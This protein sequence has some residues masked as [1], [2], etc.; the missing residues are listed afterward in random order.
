MLIP[1]IKGD[2]ERAS[3]CVQAAT[4]VGTHSRL[5]PRLVSLLKSL[6][7]HPN[8]LRPALPP[9]ALQTL[10]QQLLLLQRSNNS[11]D[12]LD[13]RQQPDHASQPVGIDSMVEE[14][15]QYVVKGD[16]ARIDEGA[17]SAE[18]GVNMQNTD[19]PESV[20]EAVFSDG[21]ARLAR[22]GAIDVRRWVLHY[23]IEVCSRVYPLHL[24][25]RQNAVV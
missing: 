6:L 17:L 13:A 18:Y 16:Y 2:V 9:L 5:R 23:A 22:S 10:F 12:H 7:V 24:L 14:L 8:S 20:T 1:E 21:V 11:P 25:R 4:L 3:W 15:V 19:D